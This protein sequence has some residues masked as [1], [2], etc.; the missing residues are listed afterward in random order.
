[1][2]LKNLFTFIFV[3]L[4]L[5]F[6][7]STCISGKNCPNNRGLC[8]KEKCVCIY[9]YTTLVNTT[10][11]NDT[12]YCFYR[13]TDRIIPFIFELLLPSVGL[14]LLGRIFHGIV[15]FISFLG[16]NLLVM[17]KHYAINYILT[18]SFFFLDFIDLIFLALAIYKDGNGAQLL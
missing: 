6:I 7:K 12:I 9:G 3:Y 1:M 14:F 5:V 15:K 16:F 13:Q 10:N 17:G 11:P 2:E 18:I 8:V 4:N